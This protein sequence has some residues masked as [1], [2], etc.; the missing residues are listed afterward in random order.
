M[1]PLYSVLPLCTPA[2]ETLSKTFSHPL[3]LVSFRI[4][5]VGESADI[6]QDWVTAVVDSDVL[7]FMSDVDLSVIL[8]KYLYLIINLCKKTA[9]KVLV[10]TKLDDFRLSSL[11]P[12]L[13]KSSLE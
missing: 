1:F 7:D 11:L 2:N 8:M 5:G 12:N 9:Y 13:F 4:K 10:D 6:G 3:I